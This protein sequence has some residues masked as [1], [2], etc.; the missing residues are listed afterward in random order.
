METS[1]TPSQ[2][3][4]VSQ[5]AAG[6]LFGGMLVSG[7]ALQ[8]AGFAA[9][10]TVSP[11]AS[12]RP[13]QLAALDGVVAQRLNVIRSSFGLAGGIMTNAYTSEVSQAAASNE[14]PALIPMTGGVVGEAGMWGMI[15]GPSSASATAAQQIVDGWVFHDGW[16][17]SKAATWNEDCTSAHAAGCDGH[18]RS[19]LSTPPIPGS[20]LYIDITTRTVSL[21]GTPA[22]SVAALFVWKTAVTPN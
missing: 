1:S 2:R 10:A 5:V 14:D 9:A 17:G 19:V 22:I 3:I 11:K 8:S 16:D 15:S 18:R 6:L 7:V 21:D 4:A 13:A 12:L 20:R